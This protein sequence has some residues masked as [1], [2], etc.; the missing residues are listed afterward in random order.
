[1]AEIW[2]FRSRH[3]KRVVHAAKLLHRCS[4]PR[5]GPAA[6]RGLRTRMQSSRGVGRSGRSAAETKLRR[7]LQMEPGLRR[8]ARRRLRAHIAGGPLLRSPP[9]P[10]AFPRNASE[11]GVLGNPPTTS[12]CVMRAAPCNNAL[13]GSWRQFDG[14]DAGVSS[15]RRLRTRCP[16]GC[17]RTRCSAAPRRCSRRRPSSAPPTGPSSGRCDPLSEVDQAALNGNPSDARI[18]TASR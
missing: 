5:L 18:N 15:R 13:A 2:R 4:S 11:R 7:R 16:R 14:A 12:R 3:K 1:M 6:A 9:L 17:W 10:D 8:R